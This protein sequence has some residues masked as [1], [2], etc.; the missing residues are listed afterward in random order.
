MKKWIKSILVDFPLGVL[1]LFLKIFKGVA[2][3]LGVLVVIVVGSFTLSTCNDDFTYSNKAAAEWITENAYHRSRTWCAL[4]VSSAI[5]AGGRTNYLLPAWA[6]SWYL[7]KLGFT[8]VSTAG[9]TPRTGD[10]CVFPSVDGHIWGHVAL[11]NGHQWVSDFKQRGIIVAKGY[12]KV[13][14]RI[15]RMK[16]GEYEDNKLINK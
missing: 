4:Y 5:W 13:K 10:V 7:P 9:Y 15:F 6:Y 16:D 11:W 8:E 12:G 1:K 14:Y 3:T 2:V